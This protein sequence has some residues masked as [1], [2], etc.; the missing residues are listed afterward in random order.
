MDT[1]KLTI[2]LTAALALCASAA[3]A[4]DGQATGRTKGGHRG[5]VTANA[6]GSKTMKFTRTITLPDGKT[7]TMTV[8][9]TVTRN[10]K[11]GAAITGTRTITTADG[12]EGKGTFQGSLTRNGDGWQWTRTE[13]GTTP[14]GEAYSSETKGGITGEDF[15][16]KTTFKGPK[17]SRTIDSAG[18]VATDA[19]G[20]RTVTGKAT[21]TDEDGKTTTRDFTRELGKNGRGI[22]GLLDGENEGLG[23]ADDPAANGGNAAGGK[24]RQHRNRSTAAQQPGA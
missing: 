12:K 6:D 7:A 24:T 1:R 10:G 4:G 11:D 16:S 19:N 5:D 15:T 20:N 9:R 21:I 3:F 13:S 8:E 22:R 18:K 14:S 2:G 23:L 17:H